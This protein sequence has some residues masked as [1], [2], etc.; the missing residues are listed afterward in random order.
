MQTLA[1]WLASGQRSD[2]FSCTL[3]LCSLYSSCSASRRKRRGTLK[4]SY[5]GSPLQ[6]C[7]F[8]CPRQ[9]SMVAK[10][11]LVVCPCALG[12]GGRLTHPTK[13][14]LFS[15]L[16]NEKAMQACK[17]DV[18]DLKYHFLISI[19]SFVAWNHIL[20]WQRWLNITSVVLFALTYP[21]CASTQ[22]YVA[23]LL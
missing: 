15:F 10:K 8:V 2:H 18:L 7:A 23:V 14:A 5:K 3:V 16:T 9:R 21:R 4:S 12:A 20:M 22:R 17:A 13:A 6:L 11:A 19:R 1:V